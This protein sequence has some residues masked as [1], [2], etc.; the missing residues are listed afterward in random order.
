MKGGE[1]VVGGK[2][3]WILGHPEKELPHNGIYVENQAA[4][5]KVVRYLALEAFK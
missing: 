3:R 5:G 2:S 4:L 1:S